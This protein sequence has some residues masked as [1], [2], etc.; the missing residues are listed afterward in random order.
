V[1]RAAAIF[2]LLA[3]AMPASISLAAG[4]GTAE[5][6]RRFL[7]AVAAYEA[8]SYHA[9]AEGFEALA[10]DGVETA[11]LTY[12]LGN[13][14]MKAGDLGRA[15]LWYERAARLAPGDPDVRYN[16][17]LARSRTR[18]APQVEGIDW[19]RLVFFWQGH[20]STRTLWLAAAGLCLLFWAALTLSLFVR[21]RSLR[22][23]GAACLVAGLVLG[24]SAAVDAVDPA[25]RNLGIVL[26]E[27][28]PVR[29]G[30]APES[31]EL[32]RLHAGA[33]VRVERSE[34]GHVRIRFAEDRVGWVPAEQV[35]RVAP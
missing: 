12:D 22:R 4:G 20:L 18:D 21:R 13:A 24:A 9:A 6:T 7:D 35:G 17:D 33:R 27:E 23:L 11:D 19:A 5:R 31:T 10:G 25:S 32:F 8:G 2:L 34:A 28:L 14:Y 29:A 3:L 26:P 15:I 1:R 16:L 30:I